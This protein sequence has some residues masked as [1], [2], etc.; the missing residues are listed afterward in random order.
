M[1]IEKLLSTRERVK[2]IKQI[3][4]SEKEFGVNEIAKK[5]KLSKGLVSKYFEILAKE[6]VIKK[7]GNKFSNLTNSKVKA[8]R[9]ML[10]VLK[11]NTKVFRKYKFVR[12]AGLYG[13]CAKGTNTDTSDVDLWIKVDKAK[14]E[15]LAELASELRKG[16]ENVKILILDDK[17]LEML[18]KKDP[19]F[20]YSLHFGSIVL[21][22]EEDEIR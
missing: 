12:S 13:S 8:I 4:Y 10:N 15:E 2:I 1:N 21:Y 9:I 7:R 19:V 6:G 20:Y 5:L 14:E 16:V 3:I 18:K 11:I 22:G 17:K